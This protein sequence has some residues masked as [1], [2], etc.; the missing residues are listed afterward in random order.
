MHRPIPTNVTSHS[1]PPTVQTD[2][3]ASGA[4]SASIWSSPATVAATSVP[5]WLALLTEALRSGKGGKAK[6]PGPEAALDP[7]VE[8]GL[9]AAARAV[10]AR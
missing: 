4:L 6:G 7:Q 2:A 3:T 9:W 1:S 5:R 8:V 10:V